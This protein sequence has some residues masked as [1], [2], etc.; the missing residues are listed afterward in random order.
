MGK[1]AVRLRR[2]VLLAVAA[3]V[4]SCGQPAPLPDAEDAAPAPA[5]F[6]RVG[7]DGGPVQVAD[8]GIGGTGSASGPRRQFDRG[9][10]GTG[11]PGGRPVN[12]KTASAAPTTGIVAVITGFAS[13]CLGGQEVA[14]DPDVPV[15]VG[16][17]PMPEDGLRAGQVALVD[18]DG[19]PDA[20]HAESISIRFEVS[21]PVEAVALQ[22]GG[23]GSL[24]VAGQA[25]AVTQATLGVRP[26]VGAW[27]SVSGLRRPDGVIE[28][29]RLDPRDP[30]EVLVHGML[31]QDGRLLRIGELVVTPEEDV[32]R[33]VGQDVTATGTLLGAGLEA[34]A[35]QPDL[36]ASDP[37]AAFAPGV[38]VLLVETFATF[39]G[40]RI[41][42]GQGF[43][44]AV[45][46][47][48]LPHPGRGVLSL[49]HGPG[50]LRVHAAGGGVVGGVGAA[51]AGERFEAAPVPNHSVGPPGGGG[52][53]GGR[54]P[55]GSGTR[56]S[57]GRQGFG[58][59]DRGGPDGS[60][61]GPGQGDG[62]PGGGSGG[63][64]PGGP[65]GGFPGGQPGGG[66]G[67]Q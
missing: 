20:L 19:A 3:A 25:V 27:V 43:S 44:A 10:G 2:W 66:R 7:P 58:P 45:G 59:G 5:A 14:I 65:Q 40:G 56:G 52:Q 17:D 4:G 49:E 28:A 15:S 55:G 32:S 11:L 36:L 35:I 33:I 48:A 37:A 62:Y 22:S 41:R 16:D 29:T 47:F 54:G 13:V 9:I 50:G 39:E 63:G 31:V 53:Q 21:G 18:A 26:A 46:G 51:P 34:D 30:G 60:Q 57:G 8:R 42:G 24:V 61:N 64:A 6:C 38:S 23:G 67:P 12:P 1:P